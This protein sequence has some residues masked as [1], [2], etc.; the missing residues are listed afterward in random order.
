MMS[1]VKECEHL[2][3]T[4]D[5][6]NGF[7]QGCNTFGM[8]YAI[9]KIY[10]KCNRLIALLKKD[11]ETKEES[12]DDT[13][14]DLAHYSVILLAYRHDGKERKSDVGQEEL[15]NTGDLVRFQH[16]HLFLEGVLQ[17]IDK[18]HDIALV[19]REGKVYSI[20]LAEVSPI[21]YDVPQISGTK[22]NPQKDK[23]NK[24]TFI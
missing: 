14:R 9:G 8:G 3:K 7:L 18:I 6:E 16:N 22:Y 10:D 23:I 13:L 5:Y 12:I 2:L 1:F 17:T 24:I 4:H 11:V 21:I 20:P 15:P 19:E